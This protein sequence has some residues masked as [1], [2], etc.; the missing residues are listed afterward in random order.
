MTGVHDDRDLRAAFRAF[1]EATAPYVRPPGATSAQHHARGRVRTRRLV[2][3]AAAALVILI[4]AG[5][6]A[7]IRGVGS[8]SLPLPAATSTPTPSAPTSPTATP[9]T[10]REG[11]PTE[12]PG[13]LLNTTLTLSWANAGADEMCGGPVTIVDGLATVMVQSTMSFDVDGDG[14]REIVAMVFCVMGQGGPAQ[15]L[16]IRPDP[17]RPTIVGTVLATEWSDGPVEPEEQGPAT[18]LGYVGLQDGT[19]RADVGNMATCCGTPRQS[20]V[21]QQRTY[22]WTGSSFAQVAGP[23]TFVADT[24][25]ADI[26]VA[27]PTLSFSAAADGYRSATLSVTVYNGGPQA[28]T[29]VSVLIVHHLGTERAGDWPGCPLPADEAIGFENYVVCQIGDIPAGHSV[30]LT[31]PM[32]REAARE[33]AERPHFTSYNG[34]VEVRTGAFYYPGVTFAVAAA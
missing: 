18:I 27:V 16:A 12:G 23:T 4:P 29:D 1:A 19:I 33:A 14:S 15:L 9:P 24:A 30:T 7:L 10:T 21:V 28:A 11:Q 6:V 26:E 25:V 17:S 32:R 3:A 2:L 20:A 34:R 13:E 31:L 22:G 5:V 8:T